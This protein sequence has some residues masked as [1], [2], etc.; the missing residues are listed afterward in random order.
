M[1]NARARA[2]QKLYHASILID[3]WR[4]D[5]KQEQV[6]SSV[7]ELAFGEAVCSHLTAAYGWFLLEVAQPAEIPEKLPCACSELPP[8]EEGLITAPE[9]LEFIQLEREPWLQRL[10]QS[11]VPDRTPS[12][13]ASL[14]APTAGSLSLVSVGGDFD[15]EEAQL[16]HD[17]L[18][19]LFD[20]MTDSLDEY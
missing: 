3:A 14:Q 2:N 20:R 19:A 11:P 16:T 1:S 7:L 18:Q 8:V 9:I 4:L 17:R 13:N 15:P 12:Y 5:L 10:L 6:A